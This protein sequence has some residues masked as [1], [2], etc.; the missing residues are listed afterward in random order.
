MKREHIPSLF[1]VED[2]AS[3][4]AVADTFVAPVGPRDVQEF[5]ERYHYSE[6]G[7]NMTWRYGLWNGVT[8]LGIVSYNLPTRS[9]C[10]SVF[11]EEH[12]PDHV[13][14]MGRLVFPD[15]APKNSESRLIA[16]SLN[17]IKRDHPEVWA[18]LTYAAPEV[19]D[20]RTGLGQIG[21]IYQA[22]NALY[23]GLGGEP[24]YYVDQKGKRRGGHLG[25]HNV[26]IARGKALGWDRRKGKMK[27][28]YVY[29][30]GSKTQ[31][32]QRRA[33]LRYPV[34]PYPKRDPS[35]AS[36]AG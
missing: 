23:T 20:P 8:L 10:M 25:G 1:D 29:I 27:H 18:V 30:L 16:G 14:H 22:T 34:L 26:T 33:M 35:S 11:G 4:P 36:T 13:W 24:T 9:A 31:R 15:A 3:M 19:I 2:V 5:C 12:G 17:L 21:I 7:G 28:R 32:R 6:T